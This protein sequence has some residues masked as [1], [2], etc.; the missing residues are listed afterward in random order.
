MLFYAKQY[1]EMIE[2]NSLQLGDVEETA[3]IPL[4]VRASETARKKARIQDNKAVEIMRSLQ[5]N[6]KNLDKILTHECVVARTIM[7]DETVKKYIEK[8][9]NA[10]CINMGCGMDNRFSRIDNGKIE[11]FNVDLPD[12][13]EVRRKVYA[14]SEREHMIPGSILDEAWCESIPDNR[15][16]IIVAEGLFMYFSQEQVKQILDIISDKF[17]YGYLIVELMN[18]SV[19][20]ENMHETV[21]YTDA[22]FGWGCKNGHALE[23]LNGR[24]ELLSENS[25]SKQMQKSTLISKIIGTII[26]KFNNRLA[27]FMWKS[28]E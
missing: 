18:Q 6:P 1:E 27:V 28:P 12:S 2:M 22:R 5:I 3:L 8:Y 13:I 20:K 7:F 16:T 24:F 9:P 25:F 19:M 21:K 11:W 4:A 15:P 23:E 10:V 17:K 14:E 26:Y